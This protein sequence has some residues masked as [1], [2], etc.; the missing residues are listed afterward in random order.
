MLAP[1]AGL[2]AAWISAGSTGLLGHPLCHAL[3]WLALGVVVCAAW[4]DWRCLRPR[5]LI[6][7]WLAGLVASIAM[8]ASSTAT[9]NVM[10]PALLLAVVA[11]F[12][13]DAGRSLRMAALAVALF[14]VYRMANT[15]IPSLWLATDWFGGI[16]G[17]AIG[18]VSGE[19]LAVGATFG[20]VD[21]LVLMAA[22]YA[23]WLVET[24]APRWCAAVWGAVGILMAQCFYLA[25]L[26]AVPNLLTFL[27]AKPADDEWFRH[28]VANLAPWKELLPW[29]LPLLA[30]LLQAGAA[31]TM[32]QRLRIAGKSPAETAEAGLRGRKQIALIVLAGAAAALL[33]VAT[34]L[35]P[36]HATLEGKR[37][38]S[39]EHGFL[40]WE[41]PRH[42]N[43]GQLSVGMYGMFGPLVESLG[44]SFSRSAE[45]SGADLDKADLLVL[46]Y[47]TRELNDV[48]LRRVQDYVEHGGKLLLLGE[49]TV[50]E[51]KPDDSFRTEESR[52]NT[53]LRPTSIHVVFDAAWFAV[54]G[55]RESYEA[56]AH[57]TT[58][59]SGDDR[60]QFGVVIGGS[61]EARWPARP[62]LIGR[63]GWAD[64][65]DEGNGATMAMLGN[66]RYDPGERLG[67]LVLAAE[68]PWGQGRVLVF[69][70]TSSFVNGVA[71]SAY[72]FVSRLLTYMAG[73]G[74]TTQ[75]PLRQVAGG[76]LALLAALLLVT[77][78]PT[79]W[80]AAAVAAG[81]SLSLAICIAITA[82]ATEIL[83]SGR[84][85]KPNNLAYID[86]AHFGAFSDASDQPD[87][88]FGLQYAL[89]RD[90]ML[91][92]SLYDLTYERLSLRWPV[93]FDR[94]A[95]IVHDG[96]TEGSRS[97]H[98]RRGH[99]HSHGRLRMLDRQP[100]SARRLR[101]HGRGDFQAL[102]REPQRIALG[103]RSGAVGLGDL[104][105][106][107]HTARA[108]VGFPRDAHRERAAGIGAFQVAVLSESAVSRFGRYGDGIE[109][110][111]ISVRQRSSVFPGWLGA[112]VRP[113]PRRLADPMQRSG[114]RSH[115][116]GN[117]R[118]AVR[119]R[120]RNGRLQDV[121]KCQVARDR[122]AAGRQGEDGGHRRHRLRDEHESREQRRHSDRRLAR[123]RRLLAV[124]SGQA[125]RLAAV[126]SDPKASVDGEQAMKRAW[127][128]TA[129]LATSWLLGLHYYHAANWICWAAIVA[130]G[131]ALFS[132]VV[133][134]WAGRIESAA[135]LALTLP[136]VWLAPWPYRAAPLLIVVG[137]APV[138][139]GVTGRRARRFS[140]GLC[141]AGMI[142]LVQIPALALYEH[143]TARSHEL[144][145]PL[146]AL[147][148]G[149]ARL[150]GA[151]STVN[152]NNILL[153]TMRKTHP[154]GGTWELFLDPPTFCFLIGGLALIVLRVWSSVA[155]ECRI[156]E[157][158]RTAGQFLL[159]TLAWLP[160]RS[161]LLMALYLHRA[162]RT[163]FE[164]PLKLFGQFWNPWLL[165]L[166]LAGPVLLAWRFVRLPIALRERRRSG[167]AC[168]APP[169]KS[170]RGV[171]CPRRGRRGRAVRRRPVLG[172]S[173]P[174]QGR[175][176]RRR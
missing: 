40:N 93:R 15:S 8:T 173:R 125:P 46:F 74:A 174:A 166:L 130:I 122:R 108:G 24:P 148:G 112:G 72:P 96:R 160:V 86:A 120:R 42:G 152:D 21:F 90:D 44:G 79:L 55:W 83:P 99:L 9:I 78:R 77:F 10:A 157:L 150:L 17:N 168:R 75:S 14:G 51:T 27:T 101:I 50:R 60:N 1:A 116:R 146:T 68:Q 7:V 100:R 76:C 3:T 34:V 137:L 104:A 43:Y 54:E 28:W 135:A 36:Y 23:L 30:A 134:R 45:L 105:R 92:L 156:S 18:R 147:V 62:L 5:Y 87:G 19:P 109:L 25:A 4:P 165:L 58:T 124:V 31:A 73:D 158:G 132:S 6:A 103:P 114:G 59:G 49:H 80:R 140:L 2:V 161:G 145:A 164:S 12:R 39:F 128:G 127:I 89:M 95:A 35:A 139:V 136:A 131:A 84:H 115:R 65:G 32:F 97:L 106:A 163:D 129:L 154:L 151:D 138:V 85:A 98:A 155:A 66:L 110:R 144:P 162:L 88:I 119:S 102:A 176:N 117:P 175:P 26:A 22:L 38:V 16:L 70:D 170:C 63:W 33:P 149:V 118:S 123:E 94:P 29:N 71:E 167:A 41:K 142:L 57:P 143:W 69:G 121:R 52:F 64:K 159:A 111:Q 169:A 67:D 107:S 20:G 113:L 126:E 13:P 56:L 61:V 153:Y 37:V 141:V 81:L 91:T 53:L 47:P 82:S 133:E 171:R 11:A 48:Q 172:S